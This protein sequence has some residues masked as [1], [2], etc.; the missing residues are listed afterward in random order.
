MKIIVALC[1]V[2]LQWSNL[3]AQKVSDFFNSSK[4]SVDFVGLDFSNAKLVGP[5]GF[6][7]PA[8]IQNYY[9]PAWNGL[10]LS[11]ISKYDVKGAI[12]KDDVN[13]H[14]GVV[15]QINQ[16]VEYL[17][18]VV[19]TTPAAF[20]EK[21]LQKMVKGYDNT[22]LNGDY[23]VSFIVHSLN[24][25]QERAYVYVVVF[26]PKNKNVLFSKRV[27]GAARGFG[28]RNYW[29]GAMYDI[30]KQIKTKEFRAWRK[31]YKK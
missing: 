26:N 12:Y 6:T 31:N 30:I 16:D 10:L 9:F 4:V 27:S 8:K 22:G 14:L 29:A 19:N 2:L 1:L 7:D 11:E 24:K 28:F 25:L 17:D 13:Y 20:T 5:E 23:G 3:N 15:E 21:E 18:L